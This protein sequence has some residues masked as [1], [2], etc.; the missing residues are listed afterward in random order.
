MKTKELIKN[1]PSSEK[2][3]E[4]NAK[5][6]TTGSEQKANDAFERAKSY[7]DQYKVRKEEGKGL[8]SEDF[9]K[10][11]KD[12]L[13]TL[14]NYTHPEKHTTDDITTNST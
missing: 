12:K 10:A 13:A 9:T 11:E 4:W 1:V 14:E 6:T 3:L 5:E 2:V 7:A 8:S